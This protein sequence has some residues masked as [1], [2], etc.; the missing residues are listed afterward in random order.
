MQ[1]DSLE[2]FLH[3]LPRIQELLG[4]ENAIA[5]SD[6]EKY[7]AYLDGTE[8]H[9]PIKPGDPV[10]E[11]SISDAALKEKKR[12]VRHVGKEVFGVPYMGLAIP[13]KDDKGVVIGAASI[14]VSL[15]IQNELKE[16]TESMDLS[17]ETLKGSTAGIASASQEFTAS[18]VNLAESIEGIKSEMDVMDSILNLIKDISDQTHLLG[19]N[20]AIEAARAGD[21]GRGF[22]V[23]AE[24]IRKLAAR[25]KESL[26]QI[27]GEMD[28]ILH[29][30]GEIS[31]SVQNIAA[32][33]EEQAATNEEVGAATQE[34]GAQSRK[35]LDLANRLLRR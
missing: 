34:L 19:L 23:V 10:K 4:K 15:A 30:V 1:G 28:K 6:R 3:C 29:A 31:T 33:A 17:L 8:I 22:N 9:V 21:L 14:A 5:L 16:L 18:V 11:G 26:K 7:L 25:T 32:T 27:S 20:A 12:V 13:L 35:L 2:Y 24:E